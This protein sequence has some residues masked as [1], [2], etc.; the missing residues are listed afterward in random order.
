MAAPTLAEVKRFLLSLL[1]AG[2][3]KLYSTAE[4]DGGTGDY[5]G[6]I[7]DGIKEYGT[8]LVEDVRT[9]TN[10]NTVTQNLPEW[11]AVMAFSDTRTAIEGSTEQ[12]QAQVISRWREHG[13]S[14]LD[15]IRAAVQPFFQYA[16]PANIQII[17][18]D[19]DALE[20]AHTYSW[21]AA[22]IPGLGTYTSTIAIGDNAPTGQMGVTCYIDLTHPTVQDLTISLIAPDGSVYFLAT[23]V[24]AGFP[25][26]GRLGSGSTGGS[27]QYKF[28]VPD[29]AG[30]GITGN[31]TLTISNSDIN[32]GNVGA[33]AAINGL[34]VEGIGRVGFTNVE[35]LGAAQF[36]FAVVYDSAL[37]TA[38][39]ID[40]DAV[41][42][43]IRRVTP[44]HCYGYLVAA[45]GGGICAIVDDPFAVV[46]FCV[47]C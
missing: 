8:D 16:D 39:A 33:G 28:Y 43:A 34:F 25:T 46:D 4:G 10:P 42:F 36:Q 30:E 23:E 44:A 41:R 31:W 15:N 21:A 38:A 32:A 5:F 24:G 35:G 19:R 18:M 47:V 13:A 45:M 12:R 2:A 40:F 7:A 17:E 26:D 22:G 27:K 6:G 3:D 14:F 1:P 9:E 37:S 29:A 20:T 11:E